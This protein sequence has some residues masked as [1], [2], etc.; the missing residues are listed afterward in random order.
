MT[1]RIVNEEQAELYQRQSALG[2]GV[3]DEV[4]VVGCGG[5]GTWVGILCAMI[6]VPKISL[7]DDDI[8][9]RHNLSRLPF[10]EESI[11][12]KKTEVLKDFIKVI[13]PECIILIH[14]G[15][16]NESDMFKLMGTV[17]DCNDDIKIQEMI[18]KY[19]KK[20]SISYISVGCN[21]NHIT[22]TSNVEKLWGPGGDRYVVTP[23][24]IVPPMLSSLCAVW[25]IVKNKHKVDLLLNIKEMFAETMASS[26]VP[27]ECSNCPMINDCE[28]CIVHSTESHELCECCPISRE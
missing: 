11:G 19:C 21:A 14:D 12:K 25:N 27:V 5:T 16:H 2:L 1:E 15:V 22:V 23:M 13:R 18:Y 8:I 20:F 26:D 10:S 9:E 3:P 17:F 24:F 28:G 7:F 4:S 6:G